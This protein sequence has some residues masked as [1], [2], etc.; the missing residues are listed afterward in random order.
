MQRMAESDLV[1]MRAETRGKVV[2]AYADLARAR[3]PREKDVPRPHRPCERESVSRRQL[4]APVLR[5]ESPGDE[6]SAASA[7]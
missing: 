1:A 3:Q 4:P 7:R 2:E 5:A 6:S